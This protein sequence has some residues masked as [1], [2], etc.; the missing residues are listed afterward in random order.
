MNAIAVL[1]DEGHLEMTKQIIYSS[2][3]F[4]KWKGEYILLAH[5]IEDTNKLQWFADRRIHIIQTKNLLDIPGETGIYYSKLHLFHPECRHWNSILYLDTDMMVQWDLN[6]LSKKRGFAAAN[7]CAKFN[8]LHQFSPRD[9]NLKTE[10]FAE[11]KNVLQGYDLFQTAFNAG[12]MVID[13]RNNTSERYKA[14]IDLAQTFHPW[15]TYGDQG[16]LNLYFQKSRIKLPY[17]YNDFYQSDDFNR[18]GFFRRK[19]PADAVIL[20][21]T[22]P[23]KPWDK[24]SEFY[25]LWHEYTQKADFL[26]E[27][28]QKGK[29]LPGWRLWRTEWIN[30]INSWW[31]VK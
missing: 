13:S 3:V 30:T 6:D 26:F 23:Y 7:D 19:S 22:Y 31:Y 4:G 21:L 24:R 14:I 25:P 18:R 9:R 8:L 28:P 12:M 10:E 17:V 20:H 27:M 29:S 11:I 5:N 1:A 15:S 2:F 16:I